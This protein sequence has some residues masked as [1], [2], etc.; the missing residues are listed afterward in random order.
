MSVPTWRIIPLN[1]WLITLS[2]SPKWV[3][4]HTYIYIYASAYVKKKLITPL[5]TQLL[6]GIVLKVGA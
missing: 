3:I 1:R 4:P 6:S 2:K 5:A